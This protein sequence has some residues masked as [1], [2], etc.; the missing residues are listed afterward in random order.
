M[1]YVDFTTTQGDIVI[2]LYDSVAPQTVANFLSYANNMV[3]GQGYTDSF[4]H[5]LVRGFVL[6]GGGFD[7]TPAA[8]NPGTITTSA[9]V[10]NEFN[11]AFSNVAGTIAMA[12]VGNDPNSATDQ[13]FFNLAD[14]SANLDKQNG[15]F[16]VFGAVTAATWP[17]V[18]QIALLPIVNAGSPFDS[19]PVQ[20]FVAGQT[21]L[22]YNNFV[23]VNKV[24]VGS[25]TAPCYAAGTRLRTARGEVAVEALREGDLMLCHSGRRAPLRWLGR[26]RVE[27]AS[28]PRPWDVNPVRILAEAFADG[29][30]GRDLVLSPDHAVFVDGVLIPVRHLVNDATIVQEAVRRISYFHVELD[31]HDVL[32]A[33][34][35]PCESYLDTDNRGAFDNVVT[36]ALHPQFSPVDRADFAAHTCAPLV[37]RGP[38]LATIRALLLARANRIGFLTSQ[39]LEIAIENPGRLSVIVPAGAARIHLVSP[40][41]FPPGELRRLG[42]AITEIILDGLPLDLDSS[43]LSAGFHASKWTPNGAWRWTDGCGVILLDPVDRPSLIELEVMWVE[44]SGCLVA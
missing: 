22:N 36:W 17:V 44:R 37:E 30:P 41:G 19:L 12:K 42:A 15:G 43:E 9:P 2:Q 18:M 5:R 31:S 13:F 29:V 8:T 1:S 32:L 21:S 35:L 27:A 14:N 4:F 16:T 10:Q 26:S 11:P 23:I 6:Q 20:N 39:L 38:L 25:G 28:H 24:T 33:E 3:V 7:E 40:C 34:G